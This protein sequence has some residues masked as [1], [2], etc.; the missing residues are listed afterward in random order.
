LALYSPTA[1]F[2]AIPLFLVH[3]SSKFAFIPAARGLV[4]FSIPSVFSTS[5]SKISAASRPADPQIAAQR[6][7]TDC[8]DG[9]RGVTAFA[10]MIFHYSS[11]AYPTIRIAYGYNGN[12][13]LRKLPFVK[14]WYSGGFMV[15]LFF[16]ISGYVLSVRA[17]RL[18]TRR[19]QDHILPVLSS[20]TFRRVLR[21]GLPSLAMSS[22]PIYVSAPDY[23]I[24]RGANTCQACGP[25]PS[26]T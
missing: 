26:S 21:L 9:I 14:I 13:N 6:A 8:L 19:G 3:A 20:M 10:V 23:W 2:R 1:L 18:M 25:I 15:F 17:V 24:S 16:V 12:S 5:S 11:H 4:S 22:S 7:S